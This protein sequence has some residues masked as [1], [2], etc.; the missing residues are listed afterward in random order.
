MIRAPAGTRERLA[1]VA[2]EA[3]YPV[4]VIREAIEREIGRRSRR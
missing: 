4:D 2:G 3:E 1:A